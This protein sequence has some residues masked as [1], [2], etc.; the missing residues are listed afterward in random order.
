VIFW[1]FD[2]LA[3]DHEQS[4]MIKLLLRREYGL[5]LYCVEGFSEDDDNSPY[6]A[7]M[8][9]LLAVF[10]AFYSKNLSSDT[11]RAKQ[12]RVEDGK[13]NGSVAPLGYELVNVAQGTPEQPAGLYIVPRVAALVRRA[14]RMYTS[15]NFSDGEIAA[16]LNKQR[17]IKVLRAGKKPFDKEFVRDML[18]NRTYTGRVSHSD[19]QY[20]GSLGDGKKSSRH[21][22]TWYEGRHQGF[23]SDELYDLCQE[24][25]AAV[26]GRHASPSRLR[27]YLLSD[28]VYCVRCT[29]NKP[30]GLVDERYGKMRPSADER[31]S[32][33]KGRYRCMC[34]DRGYEACGQA[35]VQI[36]VI[37]QQV[38]EH[39]STMTIPDGFRE[40]VEEAVRNRVENAIALQRMQEIQAIIERVDLRWD[41]GFIT[42]DDY[43]EKRRQ[44]QAEYEA[45]RPVDYDE[46]NEA[47][48]LL[49]QFRTY[50]DGCAE[51]L[52]PLEARK[53]LI[54]KIVDR[55]LVYDQSVVAV[56]LHGQF[57]LVLGKNHTAPVSIADAVEQVLL[58]QGISTSLDSSK[59]G[60]DGVRT[61]FGYAIL[62]SVLDFRT[63]LKRLLH[64]V[65]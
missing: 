41:E 36:S 7:M 1:K 2:R 62:R 52:N 54:T 30:S 48:D 10:Y 25:R 8:E 57:A 15:G 16:W 27:T 46:L 14:F 38:V 53:Q 24:V 6:S 22:K 39:L 60:S 56:V 40:R 17:I 5:K 18:Q 55:V 19:T 63:P 26:G 42:K 20:R 28:R 49:E 43:L 3:R 50:W 31:Y 45:L 13:F 64:R 32:T 9:Q 65:A 61:L 34:V 44:L 58:A 35:Q 4:V 51:Q 59:C 12:S 33:P 23:I 37:D 11:K 29:I 47:A 21:R